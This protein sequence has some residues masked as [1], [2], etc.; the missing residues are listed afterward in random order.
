MDLPTGPYTPARAWALATPPTGKNGAAW[1]ASWQRFDSGESL[2]KIAITQVKADGSAKAAIQAI[3]V[4]NHV[5][6]ALTQG[7]AVD[8]QRLAVQMSPPPS[9]NDWEALIGAEAAAASTDND[10]LPRVHG[11]SLCA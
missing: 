6:T 1:E 3:T 7:R 11:R 8:L 9:A 4:G 5:L 10:T 2:E